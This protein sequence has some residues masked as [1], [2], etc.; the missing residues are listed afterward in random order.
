MNKLCAIVTTEIPDDTDDR[1]DAQVSSGN[2]VWPWTVEGEVE[3][4]LSRKNLSRK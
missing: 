4:C 3:T 1:A 2:G